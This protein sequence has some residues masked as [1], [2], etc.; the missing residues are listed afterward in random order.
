MAR[1]MSCRNGQSLAQYISAKLEELEADS[2]RGSFLE[3]WKEVVRGRPGWREVTSN[4]YEFRT[5][6][7][8][9][10]RKEL[11]IQELLA[12][13]TEIEVKPL[14]VGFPAQAQKILVEEAREAAVAWWQ[15]HR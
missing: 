6:E 14:G 10:F 3:A 5:G 4:Q 7:H 9:E 15:K 2:S 1:W 12:R 11:P 8:L 13:M